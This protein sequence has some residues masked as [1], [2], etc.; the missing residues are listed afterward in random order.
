MTERKEEKRER[1]LEK[2]KAEREMKRKEEKEHASKQ[3]SGISY[4]LFCF[5]FEFIYL[6][7]LIICYSFACRFLSYGRLR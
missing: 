6:F 3:F 7:C 4:T 2:I 1:E 5:F